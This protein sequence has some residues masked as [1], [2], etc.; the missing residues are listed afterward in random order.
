VDAD[1]PGAS[2]WRVLVIGDEPKDLLKNHVIIQNLNEPA[3]EDTYQF[4]QWLEPGTCVRATRG[5]NNDAIK[6]VIDTAS[7]HGIRYVLLDSGWYGPEYDPNADP[8]LA[9]SAL[10]PQNEKDQILLEKYFA[11]SGGYNNTGEGVFNTNGVGFNQYGTLGD[12]GSMQVNVDIPA[13]CAYGREK[14]VGI[15]LYVNKVF[16]PDT[17][18]DAQGNLRNRFTVDE[19]FAYFEKWGVAGVKP[20]FVNVRTQ[21]HEAYMEEV[22][23]AAAKHKLVMTV[24]DEYVTTGQERTSPT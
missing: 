23:A 11:T 24:H 14:N 8:R 5:M 12:G 16:L 6:A 20:G 4:S 18:K 17:A 13:L 19:L 3:D 10:D 15:V 9:P 1:G 22:I 7:E 21:Q 2:P